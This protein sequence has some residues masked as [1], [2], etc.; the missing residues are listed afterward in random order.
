[1]H[2]RHI[3]SLH[4]ISRNLVILFFYGIFKYHRSNITSPPRFR[5]YFVW[6]V[7]FLEVYLPQVRF[8]RGHWL[9]TA[10]DQGHKFKYLESLNGLRIGIR[11]KYQWQVER[12]VII[13]MNT[14]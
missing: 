2:T 11:T 5:Y 12:K 9:L 13:N 10:N 8:V 6:V 7:S 1:M 14:I 3:L 4:K